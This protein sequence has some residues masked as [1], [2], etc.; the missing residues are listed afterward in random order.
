V[1]IV[2]IDTRPLT[3]CS[4]ARLEQQFEQDFEPKVLRHS[5]GTGE[6]WLRVWS[7]IHCT[8]TQV[9]LRSEQTQLFQPSIDRRFFSPIF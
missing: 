1:P 7:V 2:A 3:S 4:L 6:Y 8:E 9:L 5:S